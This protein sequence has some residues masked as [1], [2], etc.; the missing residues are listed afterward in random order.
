MN[1]KGCAAK[2]SQTNLSYHYSEKYLL[3][4]K[5]IFSGLLSTMY[6]CSLSLLSHKFPGRTEENHENISQPSRSPARNLNPGPP[7]Y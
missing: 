3:F 7:E 4:R 6:P 1:G 5:F 2:W